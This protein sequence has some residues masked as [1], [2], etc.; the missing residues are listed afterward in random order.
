MKRWVRKFGWRFAIGAVLTTVVLELIY[1]NLLRSVFGPLTL[2]QHLGL[3]AIVTFVYG[4]FA[5]YFILETAVLSTA[6]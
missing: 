1:Q 5:G 4:A 3:F 2:E 6:R